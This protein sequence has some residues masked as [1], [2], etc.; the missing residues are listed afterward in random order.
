VFIMKGA[1]EMNT[2]SIA[3]YTRAQLAEIYNVGADMLNMKRLGLAKDHT[4]AV[5][6]VAKL[7]ETIAQRSAVSGGK[8]AN[9]ETLLVVLL[10]KAGLYEPTEDD[11]RTAQAVAIPAPAPAPA[12]PPVEP[13]KAPQ[14]KAPPTPLAKTPAAA[15]VDTLPAFTPVT[16]PSKAKAVDAAAEPGCTQAFTVKRPTARMAFTIRKLMEH[17][18]KGLRAKR[19]DRYTNGMTLQHII[20]TEGLDQRDV[21]FYVKNGLMELVPPTAVAK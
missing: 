4:A 7:L 11:A 8:P 21:M 14:P 12:A 10:T 2:K 3:K 20:E 19:W 17:P 15:K 6:R 18:G 13:T 5:D 16:K 9:K 1:N